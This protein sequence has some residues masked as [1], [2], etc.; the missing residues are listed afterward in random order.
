MKK[1]FSW[2]VTIGIFAGF[3]LWINPNIVSDI[4]FEKNETE[5]ISRAYK[6]RESNVMVEVAGRVVLLL[7]DIKDVKNTSQQ[8]VIELDDG[9]RL[10][11]SH[12]LDVAQAVPV[13][14][15][16]AVHVKGEYDWTETGGMIHWTHKDDTGKRA[17]G[18]IEL[19]GTRYQ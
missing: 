6:N 8:F 17:G 18:W 19:S 4:R 16:S 13:G 7:P 1:L 12:N 5:R 2:L 15:S 9:H 14:V 11:V 3:A 10:Q